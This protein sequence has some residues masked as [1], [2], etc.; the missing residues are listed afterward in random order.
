MSTFLKQISHGTAKYFP[1]KM[2]THASQ[3]LLVIPFINCLQNCEFMDFRVLT[4]MQS[5]MITTAVLQRNGFQLAEEVL[6]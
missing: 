2:V 5:V 6:H 1:P 4:Y 3:I